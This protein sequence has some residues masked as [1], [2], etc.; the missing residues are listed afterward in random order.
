MAIE[1]DK[2]Y[3]KN[4][5]GVRTLDHVVR[6]SI[7]NN[8]IGM[9]YGLPQGATTK[10]NILKNGESVV[11]FEYD[12]V[13]P[14]PDGKKLIASAIFE[15]REEAS[16]YPC[17]PMGD[18]LVCRDVQIEEKVGDEFIPAYVSRPR[19][20]RKD[21]LGGFVVGDVIRVEFLLTHEALGM[22]N[23]V[24]DFFEYTP[25]SPLPVNTK[26]VGLGAVDFV[27]IVA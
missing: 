4:I 5:D 8:A 22:D 15:L 3:Y 13:Q 14:I 23:V 17:A 16:T 7:H 26:L 21:G 12:I 20:Q 19:N 25:T 6:P 2:E 10:I 9:P 18:H 24:V 11:L 1:Y 27:E